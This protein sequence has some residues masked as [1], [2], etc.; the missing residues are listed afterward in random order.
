MAGQGGVADMEALSSCKEGP[1]LIMINKRLRALKKKYNR[2][3]QIEENKAQGKQINKEQEEVLKGKLAVS[4]LIEEYEKLRPSLVAAVKE[5]IEKEVMDMRLKI[6]QESAVADEQHVNAS[7]ED[8]ELTGNQRE[9]EEQN[10]DVTEDGRSLERVAEADAVCD[11]SG[12]VEESDNVSEDVEPQMR[13]HLE[14]VGPANFER[15]LDDLLHLLYFAQLFDVP[16]VDASPSLVWTKV[17]ERSSCV[18]YDCVTEEDSSSPLEETDLNNLSLLGSLITARPPNATLSHQEALR[19]CVKHALRWLGNSDA[20]IKEDTTVTYS[21]LRERLSRILSSDYYTMVPELQIIGPQTVDASA[22]VSGQ[23]SPE[24]LI[25]AALARAGPS[26]YYG[27]QDT[28]IGPLVQGGE[29][30]LQMRNMVDP[31]NLSVDMSVATKFSPESNAPLK[32]DGETSVASIHKEDQQQAFATAD[33]TQAGA[34]QELQEEQ[35]L[36]AVNFNSDSLNHEGPHG[37]VS[38]G[39]RVSSTT[40]R[41]YGV[42]HGGQDNGHGSHPYDPRGYYSRSQNGRGSG[43]GVRGTSRSATFDGYANGQ[44]NDRTGTVPV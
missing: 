24:Q 5:E 15:E 39:D 3:L 16:P 18:S 33:A 41:G 19:Q 8:K 22:S 6:E 21:F 28:P 23:Y 42:A 43:R 44:T 36:E 7:L 9:K 13:Q 17:H 10:K 26:L 2:I 27:S 34:G 11:K 4:I 14:C 35:G 25:H 1:V 12:T 29:F 20:P 40:A 30:Y 38:Q 32:V 37:H 31:P